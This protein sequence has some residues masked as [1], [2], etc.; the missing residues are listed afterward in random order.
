MIDRQI[1]KYIYTPLLVCT[2][3]SAEGSPVH[4]VFGN[5]RI[6]QDSSIKALV[7]KRV[8]LLAEISP[9]HGINNYY[10]DLMDGLYDGANE[11]IDFETRKGD[12][13]GVL[14]EAELFRKFHN[15]RKKYFSAFLEKESNKTAIDRQFREDVKSVLSN[16]RKIDFNK[17]HADNEMISQLLIAYYENM[18]QISIAYVSLSHNE[19]LKALSWDIIRKQNKIID[20]LKTDTVL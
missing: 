17:Y 19:K 16:F 3:I 8:Q 15:E 9:K 5:W 4:F 13:I 1:R 20:L 14:H 7:H 2:L 11:L 12:T 10:I 6:R 18:D